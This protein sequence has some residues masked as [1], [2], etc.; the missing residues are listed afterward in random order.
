[1]NAD[2]YSFE[3]LWRRVLEAQFAWWHNSESSPFVKES[4]DG[5]DPRGQYRDDDDDLGW[6]HLETAS[7]DG[8]SPCYT[9]HN[10]NPVYG[11]RRERAIGYGCIT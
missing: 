6:G 11:S 1:M 3:V 5:S 9:R 4:D 8:H 10:K 2:L 7:P